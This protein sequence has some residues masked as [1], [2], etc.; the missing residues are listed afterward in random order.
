MNKIL[1]AVNTVTPNLTGTWYTCKEDAPTVETAGCQ[2]K[3]WKDA[4]VWKRWAAVYWLN[5]GTP[6]PIK[7]ATGQTLST[8]FYSTWTIGASTGIQ[9]IGAS[10]CSKTDSALGVTWTNLGLTSALTNN[11]NNILWRSTQNQNQ[12]VPACDHVVELLSSDGV[13]GIVFFPI[14]QYAWDLDDGSMPRTVYGTGP[15]TCSEIT[16]VDPGYLATE[17]GRI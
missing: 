16:L 5:Y 12:E 15:Y 1:G 4:G 6:C 8:P 9:A 7:L 13:Y 2:I 3:T 10:W 14:Q 11:T 17:A